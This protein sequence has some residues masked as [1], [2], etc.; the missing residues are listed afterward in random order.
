MKILM[1][2]AVCLFVAG[3]TTT[4][5]KKSTEPIKVF[6]FTAANEGGFVDTDQKQRSD[7][8]EDLKKELTREKLVQIVPQRELA[9]IALE[10]LGRAAAATG[11]TTTTTRGAYGVQNST[12]QNNTMLTVQVGLKAG[13]YSTIIEGVD[14]SAFK[15]W[16]VA[17]GDAIRQINKWIKDNREKLIARRSQQ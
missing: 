5:Q 4:A 8:V 10:V 16:R 3:N 12:S 6:I 9:D 15:M 7:S 13:N 17:M 11:T 14:P 2:L 1:I